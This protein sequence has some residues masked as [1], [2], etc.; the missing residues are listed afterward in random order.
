MPC[1]RPSRSPISRSQAPRAL[2]VAALFAS[3]VSAGAEPVEPPLFDC[4]TPEERARVARIEA[5]RADPDA[6]RP[7]APKFPPLFLT[8]AERTFTWAGLLYLRVSDHDE[9][10]RTRLVAP[11][12]LDHCAPRSR[13]LVT[14]LYGHRID[15]EGTAR[16]VLTYFS[17]RD[18]LADT[19]VL[20]PFFWS[21]RERETADGPVL[22]RGGAVAP[23]AFWGRDERTGAHHT[24]VPPL[25]WSW[26]DGKRDTWIGGPAFRTALKTQ[27]GESWDA[28]V[29]PLYFAGAR[30]LPGGGARRYQLVPPLLFYRR[31][32]PEEAL[33]VF[34]FG[35][36]ARDRDGHSTGV[37]PFYFSG[38]D[39][40]TGRHHTFVPP[41]Y[42]RWGDGSTTTTLAGNVL[43]R[44]REGARRFAV[45]PFYFSGEDERGFYSLVPP[46]LWRW[47][48]ND[49]ETLTTIAFPFF[50]RRTP[51]SWHM[52]V[53]PLW[54]SGET[55]GGLRYDAV[56]PL[57]FY[58]RELAEGGWELLAGNTFIRATESAFRL[59]SV[60]FVFTGQEEGGDHYTLVP[61]L[62]FFHGGDGETGTETTWAAIGGLQRRTTGFTFG[63]APLLLVHR[64]SDTSG[65]RA[66][67][68]AGNVYVRE[69]PSRRD[70]GVVPF[71]FRGR[72]KGRAPEEA[73]QYDVAPLFAHVRTPQSRTLWAG[74]YFDRET[75][76][77]ATRTR[78][79]PPL[80]ISHE[81]AGVRTDVVPPLLAF[82]RA[83]KARGTES[84]FAVQTYL[85]RRADGFTF[86]SFPFAFAGR[87]GRSHY[88]LVPPLLFWHG[89]DGET[90]ST[91]VANTYVQLREDGH[92]FRFFPLVWSGRRSESHHL[93]VPPLFW[94]WGDG[95]E[96]TTVLGTAF[97]RETKEGRA[98][99]LAPLYFG[100]R[101]GDRVYDVVLPLFAR[102]GDGD[103]TRTALFVPGYH[104]QTREGWHAGV[105]P[106]W[107]GGRDATGRYDLVPPLLL[108]RG[109]NERL[110]RTR[111][112]AVNT[113]IE[114]R[115]DGHTALSFPLFYSWR[116]GE[117]HRLLLPPLLTWHS[118][119]GREETTF[120]VNTLY[121]RREDGFTL[122]SFP[123]LHVHRSP[124]EHRTFLAPLYWRWG[125][126]RGTTTVAGNVLWAERPAE[127]EKHLAVFPFL[128]TGETPRTRYTVVPPLLAAHVSETNARGGVEST[129]W[130]ANTVY[131][132]REDGFTLT[133]VPFAHVHRSPG[134]ERTFVPPLYWSWGD[135]RETTTIAGNVYLRTA[136][137]ERELTVFPLLFHGRLRDR[138]HTYVPP[139]LFFHDG[140][141]GPDGWERTYLLNA[142]HE[143][144]AQGSRMNVVPFFFSSRGM[145]AHHTFVPP[146]Y[147][148]WGDALSETTVIGNVY[149]RERL[150]KKTFGV[151]PFYFR[152]REGDV[153]W[154]YAVPFVFHRR[155]ATRSRLTVLPLFDLQRGPGETRFLS[156]LVVHSKTPLH[157]RTVVAGLY[158]HLKGP[159]SDA[160]V[161]FPFWWDVRNRE[162]G[163]RLTTVFPLYWRYQTPEETTHLFL[164]AMWSRGQTER[165]ESWSY[166]LFPLVDVESYHPDHL[167]WQV[168]TGALGRER[169]GE[170]ERWRLAWIWTQPK[171]VSRTGNEKSAPVPG[172]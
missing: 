123:L 141:D 154:D 89:G 25:Y 4:I 74:L 82:R 60:P 24:F 144:T 3:L 162:K 92:T 170:R 96:T 169:Q 140:I 40:V 61:P 39:G 168:L 8:N 117:R 113:F 41:L 126:E 9:G 133:S 171:P 136:P 146:L 130:V 119:D 109:R 68:I 93:L 116:E 115:R 23:F 139:L 164:N 62:L 87:E 104:L 44:E 45:V 95:D 28:G 65:D 64:E 75:F 70:V 100:G 155:D 160:R 57:L 7:S 137:G 163:T 118:G 34:P 20:F 67:T 32:S 101:H 30:A 37:V 147:W 46:L 161:V 127:R 145:T 135:G 129:T 48:S 16:L 42:W 13:T 98:F 15:E 33:T 49:G 55:S 51:S 52:G 112:H 72:S 128:F 158:W 69:V 77:P 105:F 159:Q 167:R 134:K 108:Y 2:A 21:M 149:W 106:L 151:V 56:P 35:W 22:W 103:R 156:P 18:R 26:G 86:T 121:R 110:D 63:V 102:W 166:H 152:G 85:E 157:Q 84:L 79:L 125:D 11:L 80:W 1:S 142:F 99:G 27:E 71:Y 138:H 43:W 114:T 88:T 6:F 81:A 150:G 122:T 38:R 111:L 132:K 148:Q 5:I 73:W 12:F 59:A 94:R 120:A 78:L 97:L 53:V 10:T 19:D 131:R 91:L 172:S 36:H 29:A 47:G 107:F 17:R 31:E 143:R 153:A 124:R 90:E 66:L 50:G 54:F 14:P 83:D 165:G 58:R 76:N